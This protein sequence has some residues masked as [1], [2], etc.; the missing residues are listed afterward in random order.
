M[1]E[2]DI[3]FNWKNENCYVGPVLFGTIHHIESYTSPDGI[4]PERYIAKFLCAA[5]Q[6]FTCN[7]DARTYIELMAKSYIIQI[8]EYLKDSSFYAYDTVFL[9]PEGIS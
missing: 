2:M 5:T 7:F 3:K 8:G 6:I 1:P 9:P 4:V